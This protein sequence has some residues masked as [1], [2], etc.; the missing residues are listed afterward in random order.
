LIYLSPCVGKFGEDQWDGTRWHLLKPKLRLVNNKTLMH[1]E[2]DY[3]RM[4]GGSFRECLG[5]FA[6]CGL[7]RENFPQSSVLSY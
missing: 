5:G 3:G 6:A 2:F 4:I 7:F 1:P